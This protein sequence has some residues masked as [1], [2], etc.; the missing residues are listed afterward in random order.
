MRCPILP[1]STFMRNQFIFVAC[2]F[3]VASCNSSKKI[4][5]PS[6]DSILR[7]KFLD[8]YDVPNGKQF[9]GTTIGGLSGIDYDAKNDIYYMISDDR[10][11]V[12]PARFYTAKIHLKETRIDS[13]EFIDVKTILQKDGK[14][15]PNSKQDPLHTPDPEDIR[16]NPAKNEIIWSSEGERK[17]ENNILEDP[18]VIV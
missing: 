5:T 12:N 18:S 8:E 7:V 14:A 9:K 1:E 10:S 16:Y 13:V 17:P 6:P 4:I 15:Y 3:F 11:A 2:L